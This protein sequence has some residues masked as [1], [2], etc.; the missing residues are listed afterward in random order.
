MSIAS[1]R[2]GLFVCLKSLH[3]LVAWTI[4]LPK[5]KWRLGLNGW[6]IFGPKQ[7]QFPFKLNIAR[8]L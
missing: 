6:E 3:T 7:K 1:G 5:Q 2:N 8:S 4:N